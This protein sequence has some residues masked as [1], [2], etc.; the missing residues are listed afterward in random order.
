MDTS[1]QK[2][3]VE[4]QLQF[5]WMVPRLDSLFVHSHMHGKWGLHLRS[6]THQLIQHMHDRLHTVLLNCKTVVRIVT[7]YSSDNQNSD[8]EVRKSYLLIKYFLIIFNYTLP[9]T[10]VVCMLLYSTVYFM[11]FMLSLPLA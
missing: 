6:D 2:P 5:F 1:S 10:Y 11:L 9:F 7:W 4:I 3:H 8:F